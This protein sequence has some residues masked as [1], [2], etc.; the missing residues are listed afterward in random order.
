MELWQ[1]WMTDPKNDYIWEEK[2]VNQYIDIFSYW[3][4]KATIK[5]VQ[6]IPLRYDGEGYPER[7]Q[8]VVY[9]VKE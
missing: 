1:C 6:L 5:N 7:Y 4:P 2:D 8:L 3:E 9:Y